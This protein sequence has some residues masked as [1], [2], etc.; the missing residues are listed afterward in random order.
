MQEIID[1][2]DLPNVEIIAS[3]P[4]RTTIESYS[5]DIETA[6]L[7]TIARRLCTLFITN[8]YA[9]PFGIKCH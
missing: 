1:F 7:E 8:K 5:G 3:P 9:F 6:I 4:E 2:L